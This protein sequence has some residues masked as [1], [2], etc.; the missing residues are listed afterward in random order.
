[1]CSHV[2]V[3]DSPSNWAA[4]RRRQGTGHWGPAFPAVA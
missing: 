1:L 3:P 2:M 4:V